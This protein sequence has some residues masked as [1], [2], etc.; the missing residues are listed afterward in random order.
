M[1]HWTTELPKGVACRRQEG[2]GGYA[3]NGSPAGRLLGSGERSPAA[4]RSLTAAAVGAAAPAK[5]ISE[6]VSI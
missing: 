6:V 5:Q 3:L 1:V 4:A 2:G